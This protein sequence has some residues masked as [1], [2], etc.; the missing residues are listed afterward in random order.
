VVTGFLIDK[1][2]FMDTISPA[3]LCGEMISGP[4]AGVLRKRRGI[5]T[6]SKNALVVT[7]LG[8]ERDNV[9]GDKFSSSS[10]GSAES[11]KRCPFK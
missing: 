1:T 8:D 4:A 11:S 6:Q 2:E 9:D 3:C 7:R 10:E 5:S